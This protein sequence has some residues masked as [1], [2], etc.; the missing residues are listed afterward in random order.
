M[1]S[2]IVLTSALRTNL[3]TL[4][5][6]Q[7]LIDRTQNRLA[8]G[9]AVNSAL[10]GPQNFFTAQ[11]L[12]NRASD[13]GRL[14]DGIGQSV[15]A[16]EEA[17]NGVSALT[18]LIEQA[19][20]LADQAKTELNNV[21][22]SAIATSDSSELEALDA[23]EELQGNITGVA[24]GDAFSI[25]VGEDTADT[26][27]LTATT[28]LNGLVAEINDKAA[29]DDRNYSASVTNGQLQ[30]V[31]T[32]G[33]RLILT[34]TNN[35]FLS[36]IG[37]LD[38]AAINTQTFTVGSSLSISLTTSG[39]E[40]NA[41]T[42]LD[43]L[44]EFVGFT[45]TADELSVQ[46]DGGTTVDLFTGDNTAST[47]IN[48]LVDAINQAAVSGGN[49]EGLS[50]SFDDDTDSIIITGDTS[51][52]NDFSLFTAGGATVDIGQGQSVSGTELQ[53]VPGSGA[54]DATLTNLAEDF[55]EIRSQIDQLVSDANFR[56]TNLLNGDNLETVFNEDGS[57][58]LTTDGVTFTSSG[59]GIATADF[60]S[61]T[62]I[63]E[64]I[65]QIASAQDSVR[66]FGS[67]ISND[68]AI[69][70]TR[71]EFTSQT[72]NTLE[73]GADD[74]TLADQNEEG[75]NLLSLQTRQQLGVTALSLA[76]QSQ[77]SVLRLF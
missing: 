30:I 61:S 1:T 11:S 70:Q 2:D 43:D 67:T 25:Q 18:D 34:E 15:R 64:S 22:N 23:G 7:S 20:S 69:I 73:A 58:S 42:T 5:N 36:D 32:N 14:L 16:I 56:G 17:N 39:S 33:E 29:A 37:L 60:S 4:Q 41:Q 6:T 28:T 40:I 63:Q 77:Q 27:T 12:N 35:D 76:A 65:D 8:T 47:S 54:G 44:T 57:S 45:A 21:T 75:A 24:T 52:L 74:L 66:Q 53:F 3:L 72:I 68:L 50:A 38:D 31:S 59:L 9:K 10:D 51:V 46:V 49:L 71:Q 13:L 48:D 62:S 19:N 26:F 55:N